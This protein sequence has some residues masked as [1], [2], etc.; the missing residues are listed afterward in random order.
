MIDSRIPLARSGKVRVFSEIFYSN[1][2][3]QET[4]LKL[5]LVAPANQTIPRDMG[6]VWMTA[7]CMNSNQNVSTALVLI[8]H[9]S[10]VEASNEEFETL[11]DAVKLALSGQSLLITHGYIE[12]AQPYFGEVLES[13]SRDHSR[14]LLM[15]ISLF[16]AG[17]V[18][19]ISRCKKHLQNQ[20]PISRGSYYRARR[21]N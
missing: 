11:V 1:I 6:E 15:P 7:V 20:L 19:T 21:R 13:L 10:R 12:L 4:Y 5:S 9:G 8:G 14:I 2:L 17:H 16:A 18:K 3:S